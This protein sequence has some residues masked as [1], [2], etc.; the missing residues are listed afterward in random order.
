MV[1]GERVGSQVQQPRRDHAAPAP[2]LGNV[3]QVEV[4][5]LVFGQL[6]RSLALEDVEPFGKGGHHAVF[7][8]V[9]DHLDE[10]ARTGRAGV[11]IALFRA[12]IGVGGAVGGALDRAEARRQGIEDGIDRDDGFVRPA[13][14]HAEATVKA[15]DPARG[16]DIDIGDVLGG[17]SLG[18]ADIV[19]VER[20]A[21]VDHDIARRGEIGQLGNRRLG[22]LASRQ[23]DPEHLLARELPGGVFQRPGAD[24]ALFH[25]L[26]HG[27]FRHV[28]G[29]DFM[30]GPHQA[31]GDPG[32]HAAEADDGNTHLGNLLS[33]LSVRPR[34]G[35]GATVFSGFSRVPRAPA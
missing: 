13:D 29:N 14:H 28:I 30:A 10:V 26:G 16:A 9:V 3:G 17:Q 31:A 18:A 15:P 22:D 27:V 19:L 21:A 1:A 4:K 25:Q 34:S 35:L 33:I 5:A 32:A 12:R 11:D 24:R 8:A 23:H 6:V 20:V 2:C 7:D